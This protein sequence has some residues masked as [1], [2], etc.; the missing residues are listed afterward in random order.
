MNKELRFFSIFKKVQPPV[1][2][3]TVT[4]PQPAD[5]SA[6]PL[7]LIPKTNW[8]ANTEAMILGYIAEHSLPLSLAGSLVKLLQVAYRDPVSLNIQHLGFGKLR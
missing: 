8:R 3:V 6:Q 1:G 7:G 2:S 4:G 5:E